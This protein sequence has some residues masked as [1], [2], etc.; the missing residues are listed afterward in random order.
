MY[1]TPKLNF[2][3]QTTQNGAN[4]VGG[5]NNL[6]DRLNKKFKGT[7]VENWIRFWKNVFTDYRELAKDIRK[8]VKEK[9]VKSFFVFSGLGFFSYCL[10]HNPNE[11][12]FR[13]QYV[14]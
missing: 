2:I 5:V 6:A 13:A 10:T 12:L 14:E 8:D 3:N 1:K 4:V 7:I 11:T 9:P